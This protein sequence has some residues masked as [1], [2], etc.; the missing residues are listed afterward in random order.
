MVWRLWGGGGVIVDPLV[1]R[2]HYGAACLLSKSH[3][4]S[5]TQ[6]SSPF[7]KR[8][9]PKCVPFCHKCLWFK[10][11]FSRRRDESADH[12]V[13]FLFSFFFFFPKPRGEQL[14]SASFLIPRPP[15]FGFWQV[16][17]L[18]TQSKLGNRIAA[19]PSGIIY[20]AAS[21]AGRSCETI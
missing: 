21:T 14:S 2:S 11:C 6:F 5:K 15:P 17:Y 13:L 7:V 1:P 10:P 8:G 18:I 20:F 4:L 16:I 12:I 3:A 9:G 19:V